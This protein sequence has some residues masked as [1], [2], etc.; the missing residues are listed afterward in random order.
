MG[1]KGVKRKSQLSLFLL[2]SLVILLAFWFTFNFKSSVPAK[3]YK[4]AVELPDYALPLNNYIENC[5]LQTS[6]DA[7][8]LIGLQGGYIKPRHFLDNLFYI[9]SYLYYDGESY[10]PSK[11]DLEKDIAGYVMQNMDKCA[12]L[13][14]FEELG[15]KFDQSEPNASAKLDYDSVA[16]EVKYPIHIEYLNSVTTISDFSMRIPVRLGYIREVVEGIVNDTVIEPDWVSIEGL[17]K[18]DLSIEIKP[19]QP[20]IV[21]LINDKKSILGGNESY[22]FIFATEYAPSRMG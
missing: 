4:K 6:K 22:V 3:E 17:T 10:M 15:Y 2:F 18:H 14:L 19:R 12:N 11:E 9:T 8:S 5:A 16:V 21:Y 13:S 7:I 20:A 1:I